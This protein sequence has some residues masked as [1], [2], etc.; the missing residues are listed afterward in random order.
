MSLRIM[1]ASNDADK[2]SSPFEG[3]STLSTVEYRLIIAE[4]P[5]RDEYSAR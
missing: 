2:N 1:G 4:L 5:V 3:F